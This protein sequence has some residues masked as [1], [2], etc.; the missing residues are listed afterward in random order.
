M[1]LIQHEQTFTSFSEI[2]YF[3]F[4][5]LTTLNVEIYRVLTFIGYVYI[6]VI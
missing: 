2:K 4:T 5:C 6:H 1:R 3:I